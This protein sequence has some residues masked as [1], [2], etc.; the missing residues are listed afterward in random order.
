L[1]KSQ[2]DLSAWLLFFE[3]VGKLVAT[4]RSKLG[5]REYFRRIIGLSGV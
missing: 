5:G 3:I 1:Q 4:V 2:A